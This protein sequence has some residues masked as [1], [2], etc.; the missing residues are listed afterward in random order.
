M[1]RGETTVAVIDT[2]CNYLHPDLA[3][4]VLSAYAWDVTSG[5]ALAANNDRDGHGTNV[6]GAIAATANNGVYIAGA[7]YNVSILP[8]K[9]FDA[10]DEC[11][12]AYVIRAVAHVLDL[13]DAGKVSNLHV[14]N[15]SLGGL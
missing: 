9:V 13:I 11:T 2:G 10:N 1:R 15:M 8:I 3:Q 4:R 12:S 6:C 14:I 7:S 5:T